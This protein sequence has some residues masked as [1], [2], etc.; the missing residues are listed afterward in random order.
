MIEKKKQSFSLYL[1]TYLSHLTLNNVRQHASLAKFLNKNL[2]MSEIKN[3][4]AGPCIE[5]ATLTLTFNHQH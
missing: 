5:Y 2:E 1:S 4:K 3:I